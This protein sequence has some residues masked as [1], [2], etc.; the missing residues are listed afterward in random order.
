LQVKSNGTGGQ[1]GSYI[2]LSKFEQ[3]AMRSE[4]VRCL[5]NSIRKRTKGEH[6]RYMMSSPSYRLQS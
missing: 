6:Y 5:E 3:L 1:Q 4:E 2:Q